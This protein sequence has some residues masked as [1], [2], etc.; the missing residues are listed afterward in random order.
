MPDRRKYV[1]TCET[2]CAFVSFIVSNRPA[3]QNYFVSVR[4]MNLSSGTI[5]DLARKCFLLVQSLN[6]SL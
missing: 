4:Q 2:Q 6:K 3:E 1:K 5:S